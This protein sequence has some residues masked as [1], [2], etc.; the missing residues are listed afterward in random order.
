MKLVWSAFALADREAIFD[1]IAGENPLEPLQWMS[2]YNP[3]RRG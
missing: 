2:V 1:Y 3:Q